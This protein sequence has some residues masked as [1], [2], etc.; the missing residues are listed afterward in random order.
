MVMNSSSLFGVSD[1]DVLALS[2]RERESR[3]LIS[4][5]ITAYRGGAQRSA[6]ISTWIAVAYDIIAK[7]RELA[8]QGEGAARVIVTELDKAIQQNNRQRLQ[9]FEADLLRRA[10]D[11]LQLFA[12]HEFAAL[13][14]LQEDRHLCAHPAFVVENELFQPSP[15]QVRAHIVHALQYLL[16]HA[17]LQ[18]KSAIARLFADLMRPSFPTTSDEISDFLRTR[19]LGRA[20]DVLVVNLVRAIISAPFGD[21]HMQYAGKTPTLA[22]LLRE[23]ARAKRE[24]Y[25]SVIPGQVAAK[26][27]HAADEVL[28]HICPFL[29]FDGD[30]QIWERITPPDQARIR[31]L[32]ETGNLET[33]KSCSAFDALAVDA[34]SQVL[35]ER[36]NGCDESMQVSI[37]ADHPRIEFVPRALEIYADAKS[38]R[39]AELLGESLLL[40]LASFFSAEDVR[41]VLEAAGSNTQ[42]SQAFGTPDIFDDLFDATNSLISSTLPHWM[43]FVDAQIDRMGDTSA[44]YAYPG[45][46]DRLREFL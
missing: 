9:R 42:I 20:K 18:G 33:L 8:G 46:Q 2:V 34:L 19:Y 44:R 25:E 12:L 1:I 39:H 15:E 3:R 38:F 7:A 17:P 30:L 29:Y 28:L 43:E 45:L 22:I 14:R 21:E 37:I 24:I 4:E 13:E 26:L 11:E 35:V 5:A 31:R 41:I 40:P 36:F 10:H 32:L 27:E 6:L 23:I 16:V